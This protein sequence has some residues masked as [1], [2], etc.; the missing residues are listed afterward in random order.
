V[1]EHSL[2][3]AN[4]GHPRPLICGAG[5]AQYFDFA[6][7]DLPLGVEDLL[8]PVLRRVDVPE[9]S[10]F[11]IFYTDGVTEPARKPL[12]GAAELP[13]RQSSLI[14]SRHCQAQASLTNNGSFR[15]EF[16]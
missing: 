3:F 1:R 14:M 6:D 7:H 9:S 13:T 8:A 11:I 12:T 10:L 5:E 2:A 15:R 4:A 16:R